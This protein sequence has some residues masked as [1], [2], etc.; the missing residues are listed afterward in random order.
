M[1]RQLLSLLV[2][3][4][5]FPI[6][7]EQYENK[8]AQE[9]RLTAESEPLLTVA[10]CVNVMSGDFFYVDNDLVVDRA[11]PIAFSRF[12]DSGMNFMNIANSG[13]DFGN[14]VGVSYPLEL[15]FTTTKKRLSKAKG[16]KLSL[17]QRQWLEIPFEGKKAKKGKAIHA[18]INEKIFE[19][20]YTN[21]TEAMLRGEPSLVH[22][23]MKLVGDYDKPKTC[24]WVVSFNDG[25][26]RYYRFYDK[27]DNTRAGAVGD[28][29]VSRDYK[30]HL[31][32]E[33][34]PNGLRRFFYYNPKHRLEKIVTKNRDESLELNH[35]DITRENRQYSVH[36]SNGLNAS[37]TLSWK[38]G[39]VKKDKLE[40]FVLSKVGGD[41]LPDI[42]Y[43]VIGD[44]NLKYPQQ[45]FKLKNI[46]WANK[47]YLQI[48]YDKQG[49]VTTLR[50][51]TGYDSLAQELYTFDYHSGYTQVTDAL[52][53]T[54]TYRF[55]KNRLVERNEGDLRSHNYFW[56]NDVGQLL[57][58]SLSEDSNKTLECIC[59]KYDDRGNV[60]EKCEYGNITGNSADSFG[61]TKSGK[62]IGAD[63]DKRVTS[64]SYS[65][66]NMNLLLSETAPN[67]TTTKYSYE[68][69]IDST[70]FFTE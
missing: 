19:K 9:Y 37:Y 22:T 67:G 17:D 43:E 62:P 28:V 34:L 24:Q 32:E 1:T 6:S 26:K 42:T 38:E 7:A 56:D 18:A 47:N 14:C 12:Y 46:S 57:T 59:F 45:L 20:G 29:F 66:R 21:C 69:I 49:R 3:F 48:E 39:E 25:T 5:N 10:N 40:T 60:L 50:A 70:L 68:K 15:T 13:A 52:D 16:G 35:I 51:P 55:K 23:S 4:L 58:K 53:N 41:H 36:G 8:E 63:I 27:H 65:K 30:F 11:D 44:E 31:V 64:Y 33:K 2:L 61:V 54:V